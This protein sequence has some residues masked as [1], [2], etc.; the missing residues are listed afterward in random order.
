Q[1]IHFDCAAA[2]VD[3]AEQ[4]NV[5]RD[6]TPPDFSMSPRSR[7]NSPDARRSERLIT[8][9]FLASRRAGYS[10][11]ST[12]R[13]REGRG[14]ARRRGLDMNSGIARAAVSGVASR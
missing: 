5:F 10:L 11:G 9:T 6:E 3:G 2:D 4:R 7:P 14:A 8:I 1:V 12:A 13:R